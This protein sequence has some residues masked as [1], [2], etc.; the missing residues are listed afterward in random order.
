[1][2]QPAAPAP[3]AQLGGSVPGQPGVSAALQG[4]SATDGLRHAAEQAR[5]IMDDP[6]GNPYLQAKAFERLKA[7]YLNTYRQQAIKISSN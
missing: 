3:N 7:E 1:M 4:A 2:G 5:R 6:H